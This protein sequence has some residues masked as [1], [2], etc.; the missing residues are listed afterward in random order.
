MYGQSMCIISLSQHITCV[1]TSDFL[2][3]CMSD[4]QNIILL[5]IPKPHTN[6]YDGLQYNLK[7]T[8]Q[9]MV[10]MTTLSHMGMG[11]GNETNLYQEK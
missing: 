4:P 8:Q 5:A 2:W 9:L 11:S 6:C 3:V 1:T 7:F 10:Y